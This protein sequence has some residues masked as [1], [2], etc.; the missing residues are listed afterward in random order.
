MNTRIVIITGLVIAAFLAPLTVSAQV[1]VDTTA[2]QNLMT[3]Q[4]RTA[5]MFFEKWGFKMTRGFMNV[6]TF[7]VELPRNIHVETSEDPIVGPMVGFGKGLGL[8][9]TR[10]VA[11]VMDIATFGT[12]DDT[13]TVYDRFAFPYF[14]WQGW[15]KSERL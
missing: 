5:D 15:G 10:A 8:S 11:G 3:Y 14:V 13:Y 7:W 4:P 2:E 12:V 1:E 6:A 9:L